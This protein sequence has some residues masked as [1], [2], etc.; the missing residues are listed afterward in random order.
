MMARPFIERSKFHE[1]STDTH[2][3]FFWVELNYP[4]GQQFDD[5]TL[6]DAANMEFSA[7]EKILA[8]ALPSY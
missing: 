6:A 8:R 7:L 5:M 3:G 4:F 2:W 1:L